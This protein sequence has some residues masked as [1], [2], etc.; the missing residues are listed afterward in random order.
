MRLN[1]KSAKH[2][3]RSKVRIIALSNLDSKVAGKAKAIMDSAISRHNVAMLHEYET[4]NAMVD[5]LSLYSTLE[6]ISPELGSDVFPEREDALNVLN[7]VIS[8]YDDI[9]DNY[10]AA[11][12]EC[13]AEIQKNFP[14]AFNYL[15]IY[16][17]GWTVV[18]VTPL[19]KKL[20]AILEMRASLNA[21]QIAME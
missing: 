1:E 7:S 2:L 12:N 18:D 9:L 13:M 5:S 21:M 17:A 15:F 6:D 16:P 20:R 19:G 14:E 3:D 4:A 10:K 8:L 11:K